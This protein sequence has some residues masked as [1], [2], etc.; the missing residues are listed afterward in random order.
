MDFSI[1]QIIESVVPH[2]LHLHHQGPASKQVR[3]PC[4]RKPEV[5]EG[6][7]RYDKFRALKWVFRVR[8]H[9]M[10]LT[11][12]ENDPTSMERRNI[13]ELEC[14]LKAALNQCLLDG[15]RNNDYVQICL[16]CSGMDRPFEFFPSGANAT[17]VHQLLHTHALHDMLE[18]FSKVIQSGKEVFLDNDSVL[19]IYTFRP[20]T[21]GAKDGRIMFSASMEDW[22]KTSK[23]IV[24]V[25]NTNDQTCA[26]RCVVLCEYDNE[27][28]KKKFKNLARRPDKEWQDLAHELHKSLGL[29]IDEPIQLY[30]LDRLADMKQMT[31]HIFDPSIL[32]NDAS[33][34]KFA[35]HTPKRGY[36]KHCFLLRVDNHY[37]YISNINGVLN[38]FKRTGKAKFCDKCFRVF[39]TRFSHTC[40]EFEVS[41]DDEFEDIEDDLNPEVTAQGEVPKAK[42]RKIEFHPQEGME[43][44]SNTYI[45]P[46]EPK[47]QRTEKDE[48]GIERIVEKKIIYFD[49]E[50]FPNAFGRSDPEEPEPYPTKEELPPV[51]FYP[52]QP[53]PFVERVFN[54]QQYTYMQEVMYCEAQYEDGS[55]F[56]FHDL[57]SFMDWL[58]LPEHKNAYLIAH[59]G[60]IFDFQMVFREFLAPN[61]LRA[62]KLKNPLLRGNKIVSAT[63]Q[64]DIK[65]LDSYAFVS[66]AL[67]KFPA[68]FSIEEEKKGFFPHQ[69][70]RPEFWDYVGPIPHSDYYEPD[71]FPESKR[72]EFFQWHDSQIMQNVIFDF[73][74]EMKAYC[75]SDVQLLRKG[76]TKFRQEFLNLR[77]QD[78]RHIG[79]DPFDY[80][81]IAG[82]AFEGVYMRHFLPRDTIAVVPRPYKDTYSFQS[83]LW[84]EH[85][86]QTKNIHIKH[87]LNGGE[88]RFTIGDNLIPV[89]GFCEATNTIYQFHGCFYHGCPHCYESIAHTPHRYKT[90]KNKTGKQQM[91]N[92]RFGDLLAHTNLTTKNFRDAGFIVEE[93]WECQWYQYAKIHNINTSRKDLEYLKSL[94]P[95][96][97]YFGGRTNAFKLY[98]KCEGTEK[99]H[100]MDVTSMYPFV[101]S[102][103]QYFFPI[104]FPT[105]LRKERKDVMIPVEDL[106]GIMKCEVLPP[107]DLYFPVLPERSK[108]GKV[109]FHLNRMIGT[110]TSCELQKAVQM[111]YQILDIFEQHH[112][113]QK[114]NT[115]FKEYNDTFFEIKRIAKAEGNKGREAIAKMCINGPTGKWGFNPS[116]Q[117]QTRLVTET[118]EFFKYFLGPWD[119][120]ALSL[121]N[122]DLCIANITG[123]DEYTEHSRSNVVISA[124]IT[125]YARLKLYN[126]AFIPLGRNVLYTDTDSVIYLSPSGH[127]LIPVDKTGTM[128]LWTSEAFDDD[129]Y[130]TEFVSAGPKTYALKSFSGKKDISKSKG[131]SLHHNNSLIFNL[132]TL[133]EQVKSKAL[134]T[135]KDKL[136]LHKNETIM[137]RKNFNVLVEQNR[138]KILNLVYDKRHIIPLSPDSDFDSITQIDTLP[139]GHR[140]IV[141][142]DKDHDL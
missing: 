140:D 36:E 30:H 14:I 67:S 86:T 56:I 9:R 26:C 96:D 136:V 53:Y 118:D 51:I 82:V 63:I 46:T 65:L 12:H 80:L 139:F 130:F 78:G 76:M 35:Y 79:V 20:P 2:G 37:H 74:K 68:I 100:Y 83:M 13:N 106:F 126:D 98:H 129:D 121:V 15:S 60:G 52:Y 1:S 70:N 133:V 48:N 99:I 92:L 91:I 125:A 93:M 41:D 112:Y 111:G 105:V 31:I 66:H 28:D 10:R 55:T 117:K 23:S 3:H 43:K 119:Q 17:T 95:R 123:N 110:W 57:S 97:S 40:E 94:V 69:F 124:F 16:L 6:P 87:A 84:L 108:T 131:F 138:G 77:T 42:K 47:K 115:L 49:F 116:K 81:T 34:C 122:E 62:K 75:H 59:C 113:P 5:V 101:M 85:V 50:T 21:G 142:D 114:S 11:L 89:D 18:I 8:T 38:F 109:L 135:P 73:Q 58:S 19:T 141:D 103:A 39:D 107:S 45:Q 102:D 29:S 4:Q 27:K 24:R 64:N 22:M 120:V 104:G 25:N 54:T 88:A 127:H 132:S 90:F 32:T 33:I 71:N 72:K 44:V 128:G 134:G 7:V 137:R 61:Q